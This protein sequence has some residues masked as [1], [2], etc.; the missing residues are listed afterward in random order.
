MLDRSS[1]VV[2]ESRR[3]RCCRTRGT[4]LVITPDAPLLRVR[5][6]DTLLRLHLDGNLVLCGHLSGLP[7]VEPLVH[8]WS[9]AA[10]LEPSDWISLFLDASIVGAVPEEVRR[11]ITRGVVQ[12]VR[13]TVAEP[14][15]HDAEGGPHSV[16]HGAT[17]WEDAYGE[18]PMAS[19][20]RLAPQWLRGTGAVT[21][22]HDRVADAEVL[23]SE[24]GVVVAARPSLRAEDHRQD[25]R[26]RAAVAERLVLLDPLLAA[27]RFAAYG[28]GGPDE[29]SVDAHLATETWD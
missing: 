17:A 19:G 15:I 22:V 10:Q 16:A 26:I 2:R 21:Y 11:R 29:A 25:A 28:V 6:I 18:G 23:P 24:E 1:P 5:E 3:T 9:A 14:H 4:R 27:T 12:V 20:A 8:E 7:P 13:T